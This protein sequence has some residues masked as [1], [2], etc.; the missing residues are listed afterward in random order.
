L[1]TWDGVGGLTTGDLGIAGDGLP[2]A[3]QRDGKRRM[4]VIDG[5]PS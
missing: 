2:A 1:G 3:A 5:L 4:R